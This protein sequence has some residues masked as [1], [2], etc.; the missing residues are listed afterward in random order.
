M[1]RYVRHTPLETGQKYGDI[2]KD[3]ELSASAVQRFLASGTLVHVSTPPLSEIPNWDKRAETLAGVG[4]ITLA[5]LIKADT[6]GLA[7][8]LKKPGRIIKQWQDEALAWLSPPPQNKS[9]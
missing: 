3:G 7:K 2:I 9:G 6:T 4:V 8:K 1:Y 5:D